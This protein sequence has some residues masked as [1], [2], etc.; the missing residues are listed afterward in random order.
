MAAEQTEEKKKV[1]RVVFY[2]TELGERRNALLQTDEMRR[3][4]TMV[5]NL[6]NN[7]L[8][9]AARFAV[10][11]FSTIFKKLCVRMTIVQVALALRTRESMNEAADKTILVFNADQHQVEQLVKEYQLPVGCE[12]FRVIFT[13][14]RANEEFRFN[15]CVMR[16]TLK[17][18][19]EEKETVNS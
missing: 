15:S 3:A 12:E 1:I 4:S 9:K 6:L 14:G 19:V 11:V 16:D 8:D 17:A 18:A 5:E 7:E 2:Y 10:E 13:V